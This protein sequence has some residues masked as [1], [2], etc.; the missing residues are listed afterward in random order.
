MHVFNCVDTPTF[1][2]VIAKW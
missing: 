2:I 1:K